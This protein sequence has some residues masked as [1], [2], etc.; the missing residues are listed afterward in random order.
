[1]TTV[2]VLIVG[3]GPA[4][5]SCAGALVRAGFDT[6]VIDQARFPRDK[7]CA[8]WITPDV[9]RVLGLDLR[10]YGARCVL[11]PLT[12]FKV[13]MTGQAPL[14]ID[15]GRVVSYGV[16]RREFDHYLLRR[17]GAWLVEDAPVSSVERTGGR[18]IVA[19]AWS[20]RYL[21]GAG[22]HHCPV[23]RHLNPDRA[24][25]RVVV[26]QRAETRT[27]VQGLAS[28]TPELYFAPD[29]RGYG[30]IMPKGEW[31]NIGLGREDARNLPAHVRAFVADLA[32][33]GR[34]DPAGAFKWEGHAYLLASAS[35]RRAVGDH[36]LLAG[37]AA[38]VA[39]PSSGEG[40]FGAVRSGL[41]AAEAIRR[42]AL[43]GDAGALA[44][45]ASRLHV[46]LGLG[47]PARPFAAWLPPAW[48]AR[49]IDAAFRSP[50][51]MRH[52]V[53]NQTFLHGVSA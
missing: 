50:G 52:V 19:G 10:D 17:A 21:V 27:T 29:L 20:A 33:R 23:A 44:R 4:G 28:G 51:F 26:A 38:G 35:R 3:G 48:R 45:Y 16:R 7:V 46:E 6:V 53:L 2:D 8:G 18:W 39:A 12:A 42:H 11:E 30:W 31:V 24:H 43:E 40:I 14:A 41:L 47:R 49:A 32:E 34:I 37:D 15:Y 5:S 22:G 1:M 13:A 25:E 9:V 36:V